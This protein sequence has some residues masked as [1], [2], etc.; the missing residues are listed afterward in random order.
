MAVCVSGSIF[1]YE[2][3]RVRTNRFVESA[4]LSWLC[5]PLAYNLTQVM[6]ILA[7]Q[8]LIATIRGI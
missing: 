6:N 5:L 8:T 2:C 4:D 1:R 7:R 3:G